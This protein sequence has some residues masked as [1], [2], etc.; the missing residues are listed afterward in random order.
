MM[1][2]L[3]SQHRAISILF[4]T[5]FLLGYLALSNLGR[6]ELPEFG[7]SGLN[8][9][10]ILPG[11]SPDE[12]DLKVARLLQNAIIDIPGVEDVVSSSREGIMHLSVSLLEDEPDHDGLRREIA[13]IVSQVPDLP[14]ELEG[15]YVSRQFDRLFPAMTLLFSG[16]D[17]LSRHRAWLQVE[18]SLN[19]IPAI[20]QVDVLGDRERRIEV[21]L[22]PL[23]I[24]HAGLRI[25]NVTT[26]VRNSLADSGAGQISRPMD[27]LRIRT[28]SKPLNVGEIARIPINS[29]SGV[30][31][32]S[33]FASVVEVLET[34]TIRVIHENEH[35]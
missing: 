13:Q 33:E 24:Q 9:T 10:A 23:L 26:A 22:D 2:W 4:A 5:I 25:D 7:G 12:I 6:E 19:S 27:L 15:P 17:D 34:E 8:I 18:Q 32:L 14:T 31:P 21:Q 3:V 11:G 16:G 30:L 20:D 1:T 28:E 29:R 35:V